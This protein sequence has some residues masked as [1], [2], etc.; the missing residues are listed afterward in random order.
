M[1]AYHTLRLKPDMDLGHEIER[2]VT[3]NKIQAGAVM[4]CVGSLSQAVLRLADNREHTSY[5]GP[6]EIVNLV[7][8]VSVH[9]SHLHLSLSDKEGVTIGG[10]LVPGNRIYTTAEIVLISFPEV[11]YR[12]ELC[13]LSGYPEL[14]V[15][16]RK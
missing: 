12:R 7:G 3:G 10:H 11:V 8:T 4:T 16:P 5:P 9:G 14:V 13:D 6:F 1:T 15:E 2:F